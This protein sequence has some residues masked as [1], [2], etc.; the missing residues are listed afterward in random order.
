MLEGLH[1]R[2]SGTDFKEFRGEEQHR[3]NK[4][5]RF[6][7]RGEIEKN[8]IL[9]DGSFQSG[10]AIPGC[11]FVGLEMEAW[12]RETVGR[13]EKQLLQKNPWIAEKT[14]L[15][16]NCYKVFEDYK[17]EREQAEGINQ[18]KIDKEMKTDVKIWG[19]SPV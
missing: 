17:Q 18:R 15:S 5:K 6:D 10:A 14:S 12:F 7:L 3:R 19:E 13:G 16:Q 11:Q 1:P 2:L 9:R 8:D 4:S